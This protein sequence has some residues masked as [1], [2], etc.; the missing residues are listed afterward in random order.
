MK[1]RKIIDLLDLAGTVK[2]PKG[3]SKDVL[4]ARE[5]MQTHYERI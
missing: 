3:K 2:T 5:Y 1:D 4:A